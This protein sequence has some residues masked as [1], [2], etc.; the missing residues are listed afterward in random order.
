[1]FSFLPE[2]DRLAH[3]C[4]SLGWPTDPIAHLLADPDGHALAF[5]VAYD[6]AWMY[7]HHPKAQAGERADGLALLAEY[8]LPTTPEELAARPLDGPL[9]LVAPAPMSPRELQAELRSGAI[10]HAREQVRAGLAEGAIARLLASKY[11]FPPRVAAEAAAV[12][13][14]DPFRG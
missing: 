2:P 14:T 11:D 5:D 12:A 8:G 13:A 4:A 7:R 6:L 3:V 9:A 10:F 1:M